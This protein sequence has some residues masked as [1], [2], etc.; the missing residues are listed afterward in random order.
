MKTEMTIL[1]KVQKAP[2]MQDNILLLKLSDKSLN[3]ATS[4]LW[5]KMEL[6]SKTE[7]Q[8]HN[9]KSIWRHG[10]G[11]AS[12]EGVLGTRRAQGSQSEPELLSQDLTGADDHGKTAA[13]LALRHGSQPQGRKD[14]VEE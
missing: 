5:K 2:K 13:P 1:L 10:K 14:H 9:V 11:H 6:N 7:F 3:R 8:M 4:R 12:F